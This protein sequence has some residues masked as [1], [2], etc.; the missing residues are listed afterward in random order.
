[1]IKI[2]P[3]AQKV[4]FALLIYGFWAD[5]ISIAEPIKI[6]VSTAMSGDA[7]AFGVDIR[8]ALTLAN[9]KLGHGKY[10]LIFEDEKC[11]S[12]DAVSVARKLIEID[13]VKYALGFPC[14]NT[15]MATAPIYERAGVTVITSSATSGDK[16]DIGKHIFR[17]FPSDV[18]GAELLARYIGK[19]SKKLAVIS[20]QDE[21]PAVMERTVKKVL[22]TSF[23][24]VEVQSIDYLHGETDF[25]TLA[26]EIERDGAD[27]I[28]VNA[29]TD[30]SFITMVKQ[31]RTMK[32]KGNLYAAYL[33]ASK[34][35]RDALGKDVDG[36]I[37]CNLPVADELV[38]AQGREFMEE[39]RKRFGE[40]QSGFP[41][42]PTSLEAF[43]ALDLTITSGNNP[44]DYLKSTKFRGGILPNYS[45]DEHGA[46]Q[47]I[48]FQIQE[49]KNS[50]IE[51]I[52]EK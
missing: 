11:I 29:N 20:E 34:T 13:H 2:L 26:L 40:P 7:V 41:V 38:T 23:P 19:H 28:F 27:A 42:V 6:G 52:R 18:F 37:Y 49:I 22:N 17:L 3:H 43:R 33:P 1:M 21:Y 50:Q 30:A 24:K 48:D 12:R 36:F 15:L 51:V 35:V 14:N 46:V 9:E 4:I 10:E 44:E 39:F 8:N 25:R 31:I 32:F 16:L 45:F 47:G 5:Q